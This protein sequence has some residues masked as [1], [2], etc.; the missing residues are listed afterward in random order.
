MGNVFINGIK[1]LSRSCHFLFSL[2]AGAFYMTLFL[3][4]NTPRHLLGYNV[5]KAT[6]SHLCG[7]TRLHHTPC[8]DKGMSYSGRQ[9]REELYIL[10]F[11]PHYAR[12]AFCASLCYT[13]LGVCLAPFVTASVP[14]CTAFPLPTIHA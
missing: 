9:S 11:I 14:P 7:G 4:V 2:H 3:H 10:I 5:P 8:L 1:P 12:R 13:Q 6:S